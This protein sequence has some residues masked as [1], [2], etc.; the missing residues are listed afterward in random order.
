MEAGG[1]YRW[2]P[3]TRPASERLSLHPRCSRSVFPTVHPRPRRREGNPH[4]GN[5]SAP[6][7]A[8]AS[9]SVPRVL[10]ATDADWIHHTVDAALAGDDIE[11]LR[12]NEGVEV[13]PA[14]RDGDFDLVVLDLQIGNMGGMAAC[15]EL[16]LDES[17]DLLPHVPVLMLLD[18]DV[19]AF[20]AARSEADGWVVKPLDSFSLRRAAT[21][22]L[23]GQ[24][25]KPEPG[26]ATV[27]EVLDDVSAER[28]EAE[29]VAQAAADAAA[30]AETQAPIEAAVVEAQAEGD[31]AQAADNAGAADD[32]AAGDGPTAEGSDADGELPT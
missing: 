13:R 11:L 28:A 6:S 31:P 22:L 20:L 15:M 12:V 10:L 3:T 25:W 19:D 1:W 29:A 18:R 26:P 24:E 21:A 16:R 8:L 2:G 9:P 5:S 30:E 27:V 14:V 17:V 4:N 7:R 32:E 23:A